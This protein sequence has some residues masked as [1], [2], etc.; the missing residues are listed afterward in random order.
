LT[1]ALRTIE[2]Y[3]QHAKTPENA[4]Q[5]RSNIEPMSMDT[6]IG[7]MLSSRVLGNLWYLCVDM[8]GGYNCGLLRHVSCS[9][10]MYPSDNV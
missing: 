6:R 4:T 7:G 9:A 3:N 5:T 2:I 10:Q 1:V 8:L